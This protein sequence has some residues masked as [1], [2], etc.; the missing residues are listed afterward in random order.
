V[1]NQG[2]IL[3]NAENIQLRQ[4]SEITTNSLDTGTGGNIEID[5]DVLLAIENSDIS[6]NALA[7][8][9]GQ[10]I[11]NAGAI[12]GTQF[13]QQQTNASDITA[14]SELG[15]EF[16]GTV[17]LNTQFDPSSAVIELP[18]TV[19]DPAALIAQEFCRQRGS[20]EFVNTGRG[21]LPPSPQESLRSEETVV[22]LMELPT[23]ESRRH[24]TPSRQNSTVSRT[25]NEPI[26]SLDIVPARGW[27]RNE[28]GEVILVSYDPTKTGVQRPRQGTIHCQP[29]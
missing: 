23:V 26:S 25:A 20:S 27:I 1:G 22:E 5:T 19:V 28:K 21:G 13:R 14:T 16:S 12:F 29:N 4:G 6:A 18:V 2:N 11:I 7:G 3:L 10:V 9:G 15:A 17:E 8:P 24:H